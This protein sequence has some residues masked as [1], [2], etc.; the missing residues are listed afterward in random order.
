MQ[1]KAHV[2]STGA[3]VVMEALRT[4][5]MAQTIDAKPGTV[6]RDEQQQARTASERA[7]ERARERERIETERE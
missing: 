4:A 3:S 5:N 1:E 2:V 7:S 6:A